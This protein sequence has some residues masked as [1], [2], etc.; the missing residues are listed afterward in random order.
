MPPVGMSWVGERRGGREGGRAGGRRTSMQ[1]CPLLPSNLTDRVSP[2]LYSLPE[3]KEISPR[4]TAMGVC[5]L[6]FS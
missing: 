6:L 1:Y 3:G 2:L 4:Y 5:R